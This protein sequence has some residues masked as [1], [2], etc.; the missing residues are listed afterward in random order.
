MPY[1]CSV[2][3]CTFKNLS[4]E[5]VGVKTNSNAD[6]SIGAKVQMELEYTSSEDIA[7]SRIRFN[8]TLFTPSLPLVDPVSTIAGY[9]FEVEATANVGDI[10]AL[11]FATASAYESCNQNVEA[12][13]EILDTDRAVIRFTF[14]MTMDLSQAINGQIL[15]NEKRLLAVHRNAVTMLPTASPQNVY[16]FNNRGV[17]SFVRFQS[18]AGEVFVLRHWEAY[19]SRFYTRG[20][21]NNTA[22]PPSAEL[23]SVPYG[24]E[25]ELKRG[26]EV[27]VSLSQYEETEVS[28]YLVDQSPTLAV[29]QRFTAYLIDNAVGDNLSTFQQQ[30][31]CENYGSESEFGVTLDGDDLGGNIIGVTACY[32]SVTHQ[33]TPSIRLRFK[34]GTAVDPTRLYSIIVVA[35]G[36]PGVGNDTFTNSYILYNVGANGLPAAPPLTSDEFEGNILDYNTDPGTDNVI[37]T[38]VDHLRCVVRVNRNA[39][40]ALPQSTALDSIW[41]DSMRTINVQFIDEATNLAVWENNF[42]KVGSLWTGNGTN[43][44]EETI[45]GGWNEYS[46]WLHT[47]YPN[48]GGNPDFSNITLK[49]LWS[50]VVEFPAIP[51]WRVEYRYPQRILV[52]GYGNFTKQIQSIELIDY[53]SGMPLTNLCQGDIALVKVTLD[54]TQDNG[55]DWNIRVKWALE[56]YGFATN[57]DARPSNTPEE[58][59]Y[60]GN[61]AQL[62][63][64]EIELLPATFEDNNGTLEAAFTFDYSGIPVGQ[65]PCIYVIA[66]PVNG[67]CP[68]PVINLAQSVDDCL[69]SAFTIEIDVAN[70]EVFVV[71][72]LSYSINNGPA[73]TDMSGPNLYILGP[74]GC[75][76]IVKVQVIRAGDGACH[77]DL[78]SFTSGCGPCCDYP[79]MPVMENILYWCTADE[80]AGLE[81]G[82]SPGDTFLIR[83]LPNATP[84]GSTLFEQ[85]TGNK[86]TWNGSSWDIQVLAPG[87]VIYITSAGSSLNDYDKYFVVRGAANGTALYPSGKFARE[88]LYPARDNDSDPAG[89]HKAMS[90]STYTNVYANES[91]YSECRIGIAQVFSPL[92]A[93]WVDLYTASEEDHMTVA[94][95]DYDNINTRIAWYGGPTGTFFQGY[96]RTRFFA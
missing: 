22:N 26:S 4:A 20:L 52:N 40:D 46:L 17:F 64:P 93:I 39:Y 63:Q 5:D 82:A 19:Q 79:N 3:S 18:A 80:Q 56:P 65:K 58:E 87:T 12:E 2:V 51:T 86:A 34:V 71:E 55:L 38:I 30:Y 37:S 32:A 78:G 73:I 8:P 16:N 83:D 35:C 66:E 96:S 84:P 25:F 94:G 50:F 62:N 33:S 69:S 27:V 54:E 60:S 7:P 47:A 57:N 9:Q 74:F 92:D 6:A 53:P 76:D 67:L 11:P 91:G 43:I 14:V 29:G 21:P 13:L 61:F 15:P 95:I 77:Y 28:L 72:G 81:A 68:E 24:Y 75:T 90:I 45:D 41:N 1:T 85:N 59:S 70:D 88:W 48:I 44:I 36:V 89:G 31:G 10:I 23:S 42:T 49:V